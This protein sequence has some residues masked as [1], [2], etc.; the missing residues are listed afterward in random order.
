MFRCAL[1]DMRGRARARFSG[2][3]GPL[4]AGLSA[5]TGYEISLLAARVKHGEKID[6]EAV[7]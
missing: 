2:L 1:S 6:I 3:V 4:L 5:H 7:R